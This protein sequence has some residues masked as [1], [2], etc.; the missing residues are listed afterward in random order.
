MNQWY[1]KDF[2]RN[3]VDMHIPNGEGY[4]DKFDPAKYAENIK[5]S[6]ASVA[7]IYGSNCLGLCLFDTETGYRHQQAQKR[8]LFGETVRELL[9]YT[10]VLLHRSSILDSVFISPDHPF[11][12]AWPAH[13]TAQ[14]PP[15]HP[16]PLWLC[17]Q[18][19]DHACPSA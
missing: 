13:R 7:Y 6:G 10:A 15:P 3:L 11:Q 18:S 4:L 19:P 16:A 9:S 2:F 17:E 12:I 8:D 1:K 14:W 5:R